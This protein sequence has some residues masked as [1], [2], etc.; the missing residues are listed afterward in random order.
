MY[1]EKGICMGKK[2]KCL[3]SCKPFKIPPLNH[4]YSWSLWQEAFNGTDQCPPRVPRREG[5]HAPPPLLHKMCN[6]S[7]TIRIPTLK[8]YI[9]LILMIRHIQ[10]PRPWV[11][12]PR[13]PPCPYMV[14]TLQ[15]FSSLELLGRFPI[16]LVCS[17]GD[18]GPIIVC[19]NDDPGMTL[20]Y[21][22]P[23]SNL[24]T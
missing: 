19:S 23:R 9:F 16:N 24:V 5:G 7:E 20:T 11:A 12:W 13:W 1:G 21:F 14:K 15:K 4:I 3:I 8:P 18:S 10:Q 6:S 22:R 2:S 17:I